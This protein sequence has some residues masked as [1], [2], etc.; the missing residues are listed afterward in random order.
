MFQH[1]HSASRVNLF[2]NN[3]LAATDERLE[4]FVAPYVRSWGFPEFDAFNRG[5]YLG[6]FNYLIDVFAQRSWSVDTLLATDSQTLVRLSIRGYHHE[7]FMGL[8]ATGAYLEFGSHLLVRVRDDLISESWMYKKSLR[9]M[10]KKGDVF[11]WMP[12][13]KTTGIG[14][15]KVGCC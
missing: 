12:D 7:E 10:T 15:P 11:E 6:F 3:A 1:Q 2:L 5:E 4:S 14:M 8:P 9:M 13:A